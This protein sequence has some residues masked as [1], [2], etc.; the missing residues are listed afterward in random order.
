MISVGGCTRRTRRARWRWGAAVL[1]G[2]GVFAA[3]GPR[4]VEG[5]ATQNAGTTPFLDMYGESDLRG[6]CDDQY[7]NDLCTVDTED[8]LAAALVETGADIVMLQEIWDQSRCGE[9]EWPEEAWG[10]PFACSAGEAHQLQRVLPETHRFACAEGGR[11]TLTCA[12]FHE[13]VLQPT[14]P[15]GSAVTCEDRDC[16]AALQGVETSC[17]GDAALAILHGEVRGGPVALASI[18]LQ[19]G[20]LSEDASCRAAQLE[21]LGAALSTLP[22][23]TRLY[24][25][26]D[27]NFDPSV[28]DGADTDALTALVEDLGLTRHSPNAVTHSIVEWEIDLLFTRGWDSATTATC[29]VRFVD[30][31]QDPPMIDHGLLHCR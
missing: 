23:D 28:S 27:F 11:D 31:N 6:V 16:S 5:L 18:H 3:C 7:C 14:S 22:Q 19:S 21:D 1:S 13:E 15:G 20:V 9:G 2:L 17:T 12:A 8:R 29:E 4:P 26:G 30:E 25:A 24:L 10:E